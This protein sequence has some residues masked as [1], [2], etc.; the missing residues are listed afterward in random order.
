MPHGVVPRG[1][2]HTGWGMARSILDELKRV[3]L[4]Q[5]TAI[6]TPVANLHGAAPSPVS[7]LTTAV[8]ASWRVLQLAGTYDTVESFYQA[9]GVAGA[10]PQSQRLTTTTG[11]VTAAS[12]SS[13]ATTFLFRGVFTLAQA[14]AFVLAVDSGSTTTAPYL[15]VLDD[16]V[17]KRGTGSGEV[18]VRADQ[19]THVLEVLVTGRVAG[20]S[21][22]ADLPVVTTDE[23]L[24]APVWADLTTGYRDPATGST[25]N[26]LS[27]YVNPRAGGWVVLRRT[28]DVLA[29]IAV[30]GSSDGTGQCTIELLGDVA[31]SVGDTLYAGP[32]AMGTVL[33]AAYNVDTTQTVVRV[34][35]ASGITDSSS[36]WLGRA[37]STVS[38]TELARVARTTSGGMVTWR[39]TDVA[40]GD[41]YEY[42]LQAYGL[43]D[44]TTRSAAS[45]PRVVRAGDTEPPASITFAAG[46]PVYA[47]RMVRVKFATPTDDD[48]AGVRVYYRAQATGTATGG[49][50]STLDDSTAPFT[51]AA[52]V[53]W[54][55]RI[56]GGTGEGQVRLVT[57]NTTSQCTVDEPWATVPDA[58]S[59]YVVYLDTAVLTDRGL[60][61]TDDSLVFEPVAV[62]PAGPDQLY[63][64]RTFDRVG[65]EQSEFDCATFTLDP[66]TE[67]IS[68][69]AFDQVAIRLVSADATTVTLEVTATNDAGTPQVRL[70]E[71]LGSSTVTTGAAVGTFVA[72]GSTWVLTRPPALTE[73]AQATFESFLDGSVSDEDAFTIAEQGRDTTP[74]AVS[75]KVTATTATNVTVQVTATDP[76]SASTSITLLVA[77]TGTGSAI[78]PVSVSGSGTVV[79]NYTVPRP[80]FG[81]GTTRVV[82]RATATGRLDDTDAVD[83]P[84]QDRDTLFCQ[85]SATITAT[86]ATS[87]TVLVTAPAVGGATP[88]VK[89]VAIQGTATKTSGAAAGAYQTQ[90]GTANSWVFTRPA[91]GAGTA[92]VQFRA[93]A[94]TAVDDDTYLV[95]PEQERDTLF[96]NC[97]ITQTAQSAT[98]TTYTVTA[99]TPSGATG[100]P[101]ITLVSLSGATLNSG[102]AVGVA[103]TQSAGNNVWVLNRGAAIGASGQAVFRADL[104]GTVSDSAVV[105]VNEQGRDTVALSANAKVTATTLTTLTVRVTCVDPVSSV[106]GT[107]TIDSSTGASV[108][109][110][111]S[112]AIAVGGGFVDYTI[113]RPAYGGGA[114]RVV[115]KYAV[116]GRTDAFDAVDVPEQQRDTLFLNCKITQTSQTA[117]TTTYTVTAATPPGA[118]GT[119]TLTLESLSGATIASGGAVGATRAQDG[120]NNV[121]TFNRGAALGPSGQAVFRADLAG[122][123]S[124]AAIVTINEQS[125]DASGE[126]YT[127]CSATITATSATSVT[128]LVTAPTINAVAPQVELVAI[129]GSAT[130]TAGAAAAALQTQNGTANVWTFTRPA[131]GSGTATAQFRSV[132]AGS[133]DDDTY[134]S[135]PEQ[136]RDTIALQVVATVTSVSSTSLTVHVQVDDP[137]GASLSTSVATA[138][139][140]SGSVSPTTPQA[141]T[142]G[143]FASYTITRP[144]FGAGT[145]RVVFTATVSGR[146]A[147]I[148]AVDVPEQGRDTVALTANAVV[149]A[150]TLTTL[151]VRVTCVDPVSSAAGALTVNSSTG[152][153]SVS[154]NTSQAIAAGGGFVDYT[155]TRPAFGAGT[156]RVV[157]KYAVTGRTDA[158]DA[159]DVPEQQRDTIGLL[160]A[161]TVTATTTTQ[162]TVRVTVTDPVSAN[163]ISLAV[164]S[165]GATVSPSTAQAVAAGGG[166]VDYTVTRPA[167]GAGTGR[168]VWTATSTGRVAGVDAVDVPEQAGDV[169]PGQ[170][171]L[172][173]PAF[174]NG[175]SGIL[176]YDNLASN[177]VHHSLV[178]DNTAPNAS[179]QFL[180]INVDSATTPGVTVDPGFGGFTVSISPDSGSYQLN[181]YH[182]GAALTWRVR[183][184]IPVGYTINWAANA[185]GTGAT[186]TAL[187]PMAG[188]GAWMDYKWLTQVGTAGTFSTI[189]FFYLTGAGTGPIQWDVAQVTANDANQTALGTLFLRCAITQTAVSATTVTYLVTSTTPPGGTGTPTV[190]LLATNNCSISS[191]AAANAYQAQNG[192]ANVWVV[193]RPAFGAGTAWVQ[194]GAQLAGTVA[195]TDMIS[196]PEQGRDTVALS[197]KAEVVSITATTITTRVTA[198]DPYSVGGITVTPIFAGGGGS[199]S[200]STAQAYVSGGY[201]DWTITR[202]PFGAGAARALFVATAANRVQDTDA[203]DVPEANR[204]TVPLAMSIAVLSATDTYTRVRVTVTDPIPQGASTLSLTATAVNAT[205]VDAT[206]GTL[207]SPISMSS[208]G[209]KDYDVYR[210]AAGS[211]VGRAVFTVSNANRVSAVDAV[212]VA[213]LERDPPQVDVTVTSDATN[214]YITASTTNSSTL[215]YKIDNAGVAGSYASYT[216]A[217]TVPRNATGGGDKV[218]TIKA[219]KSGQ[220]KLSTVTVSSA[221]PSG[222][223]LTSVVGTANLSTNQLTI[224]FSA[225]GFP[226]GTQY[227]VWWTV[228]AT[229][230]GDGKSG[231]LD[232]TTSGHVFGVGNFPSSTPSGSITVDAVNNGQVIATKRRAGPFAL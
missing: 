69:E 217:L 228:D 46:F 32:E 76:M 216:G 2:G 170:Q 161:A 26:T 185:F 18:T 29:V 101:T 84:P 189:G 70:K 9:L 114:G 61:G 93:N 25:S 133:V 181:T 33:Q 203:V 155:V 192:S 45:D 36:Q 187:T 163:A 199:I 22:P 49:G 74:L 8:E 113:T 43:F 31:L 42:A 183:A 157:F 17:L 126:T 78:S 166:F 207:T 79:Q 54:S 110:N 64:F 60:P 198:L 89:L 95:I 23:A 184:K 37:A 196:V 222:F 99:A 220:E 214:Y 75:A 109:P 115:F 142:T 139:A 56:S 112:Q 63:H 82:W 153:P 124:D 98:T 205:V 137:L 57:A 186:V 1:V 120:T 164:A 132:L 209:I 66:S 91:F 182:R 34:R 59:T 10:T 39:D 229:T 106:A 218:V 171:I 27:W 125:Q 35:L 130:K 168:A 13:E 119:P 38:F 86:T 92:S 4:A 83:V 71:L 169:N 212:D 230:T 156:G 226:S 3:V 12:S 223:T 102:G 5:T 53:G 165:T 50:A 145:G 231:G 67:I 202:P 30:V 55:V 167:F 103:R 14:R 175:L 104:A 152:V 58:T 88:Q 87:V 190:A 141:V 227:N 151:T 73:P 6:G 140:G 197:L 213:A 159:V 127:Q 158:F 105:T 177:H 16:R 90:N 111:T 47:Y 96:L 180:R 200:P 107:L 72:S 62:D 191:G 94:A 24:A 138:Y 147:G 81:S 204:D 52:L 136:G 211:G 51:A 162:V 15:V 44:P 48:Y 28:D 19:G 121:W 108:S 123:V 172:A 210:P 224:T 80:A 173:N 144:A 117:T 154:P 65:H 174:G 134:L 85:C 208:G 11:I 128:V 193:N 118:T 219:S 129:Q 221:P 160:V 131:F 206:S 201:I 122:T 225:T 232:N 41:Y 135:I 149:T 40:Y 195:D 148:D 150:T 146:A 188:T 215:T 176:V 77:D 143:S 97:V 194:F 21:V 20:V 178:V 179:G 7:A 68:S 116:S 100:T